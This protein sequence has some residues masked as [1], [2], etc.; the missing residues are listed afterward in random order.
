MCDARV[1]PNIITHVEIDKVSLSFYSDEEIK[2]LSV[3]K[4]YNPVIFDSLLYPLPGGAHDSALGPMDNNESCVT[5][6]LRASFCPG[7]FGHIQLPLIVYNPVMFHLL[8]KL[9]KKSCFVCH[10]FLFKSPL[11]VIM[12]EGKLR[13]ASA[14]FVPEA[15]QLEEIILSEEMK[16]S[17]PDNIQ[18]AIDLIIADKLGDTEEIDERETR[19]VKQYKNT[20]INDL[21]RASGA[22]TTCKNCE[23]PVRVVRQD[24]C[25]K[26]S[27][28]PLSGRKV[29]RY[30]DAWDKVHTNSLDNSDMTDQEEEELLISRKEIDMKWCTTNVLITP[31]EVREHMQQLWQSE[32]SLIN[33]LFNGYSK[34]NAGQKFDHS[35]FFLSILPVTPSNCRPM[36]HF[37]GQSYEGPQTANIKNI[38]IR[39]TEM[40]KAMKDLKEKEDKT[41]KDYEQFQYIWGQLQN[42]VNGFFDSDLN[43]I[44]TQKISTGIRQLLEHKQ[45]LF[46]QHMMGKRVDYSARSVISPD[47]NIDVDEIGIPMVFATNLTFPEPVT[48][49]NVKHLRQAIVNGPLVHPGA[50]HVEDSDGTRILLNAKNK[51]QR[52]AIARQL[53]TPS[54]LGKAQVSK[55]VHR[56]LHNGDILLVNRQPTLHR[57]SIMAHKARV[58]SDEK[59]LRLH[60]ANCKAYNA[61]FDGDEMNIHLPQ[62][63]I[64]RSEAINLLSTPHQYLTPKDGSPLSGLIQDHVIGGVLLTIRGRMLDV[65]LYQQLVYSALPEFNHRIILIPPCQIKPKK[66]WSGKQVISTILMNLLPKSE[67]LISLQGKTKTGSMLW[68]QERHMSENEVIIQNGELLCGVLDKSQFGSSQFGLVHGCHELYG[69]VVSSKLLSA[70]ARLFTVFLQYHGF[71]MGIQDLLL[72]EE[73]E[74]LRDSILAKSETAGITAARELFS[75]EN[76]DEAT[77]REKYKQLYLTGGPSAKVRADMAF[78][79]QANIINNELNT[80]LNT[81]YLKAFPHNALH[82]MVDAGAKGSAVNRL[83]ISALLGQIELEGARPPLMTSGRSLPCSEPYDLNLKAGGFV[84]GR[85]LTGISPRE[86][87]FHCMAGREGLIDTAVKTSRS[88]YL[89]RCLVKHLEGLKV[90][91]DLTVRDSDGSVIQF[92]Y[93]EDGINPEY[94]AYLNPEQFRFVTKNI[95][96]MNRRLLS[97][98]A[99]P[100]LKPGLAREYIDKINAKVSKR[101]RKLNS[102]NSEYLL[103]KSSQA[104]PFLTFYSQYS[105][106]FRIDSSQDIEMPELNYRKLWQLAA[107]DHWYHLTEDEMDRYYKYSQTCYDTVQSVYQPDVHIG[108][109]SEKMQCL[110]S[111]YLSTEFDTTADITPEEFRTCMELKYLNSLCQPGDPVGLLAAQSIGEPS[112][113]MTLNTFHFAGRGE[114]NVTLGIPRLREI[115]MTASGKIST[116]CIEIPLLKGLD[117]NIAQEVERSLKK[118]T[119]EEVLEKFEVFDSIVSDASHSRITST[120]NF[121][122]NL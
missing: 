28:M 93:G 3:Q 24:F 77:L 58:L 53:L 54:T 20:L 72:T 46:R 120:I 104:N 114:M 41:T 75:A 70:F 26:F 22:A 69:S 71:T 81:M 21:L 66:R 34:S 80:K 117:K 97:E 103:C 38:L 57:P 30:L 96:A 102:T 74:K 39:V 15:I 6:G 12:L 85:F 51:S 99:V 88:G 78:K 4:I 7:H 10:R 43:Y 84:S 55:K 106:G 8:Y 119:V 18:E 68:S 49:W 65:Q 16:E 79:K 89:Q 48:P 50:T 1:V 27:L 36:A 37:N 108:S 94:T 82:L 63:Q 101:A 52:E 29:K 61:D 40:Q 100:Q 2:K 95:T 122:N 107:V 14:G 35:I 109:I 86:Y 19:H 105:K 25:S 110:I 91:Y 23:A 112:T 121:S 67:E 111:N 59:T 87:F 116:P 33:A 11:D 17:N 60:Y 73:G 115:I 32:T 92:L 62:N 31:L 90:N 45:G 98:S 47:L 118:I 113:Q 9:L 42:S 76:D 56:H 64:A 5:C 83:Q 44:R 13:L